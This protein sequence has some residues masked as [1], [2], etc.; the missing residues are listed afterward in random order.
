MFLCYEQNDIFGI[1]ILFEITMTNPLI[2]QSTWV[3]C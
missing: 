2:V 3:F 1:K